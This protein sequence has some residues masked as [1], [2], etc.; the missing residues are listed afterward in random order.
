MNYQGIYDQLVLKAQLRPDPEGYAEKHHIIPRCLGGG[1]GDNIVALTAREHFMAH[2]LLCKMF[3]DHG[4]LAVAAFLMA[5]AVQAESSSGKGVRVT[6]HTYERLR[7]AHIKSMRGRELSTETRAKLSAA[8]MGEKNPSYG[9]S[10]SKETRAKLSAA[11]KGE[12]NPNYGKSPS[13][14]TRAKQSAAKKGKKQ[15][16]V[17]CPHCGKEGGAAT[18]KRWHFNN[19]KQRYVE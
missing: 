7:I 10:P 12:K 4:G 3:P 19:C 5:G 16:R 1:E 8:K 11:L 13:K 15:K 2:L 14:E 6:S 17:D 18:M 9:K